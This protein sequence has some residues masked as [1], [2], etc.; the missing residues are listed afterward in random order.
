MSGKLK[1]TTLWAAALAIALGTGIPSAAARGVSPA[2]EH[3]A[4]PALSQPDT[5]S[6]WSKGA[7]TEPSVSDPASGKPSD[8]KT[9][10]TQKSK[11]SK[12]EKSARSQDLKKSQ[13]KELEARGRSIQGVRLGERVNFEHGVRGGI[14]NI[15]ED[16]IYRA[17][18]FL[19]DFL[20]DSLFTALPQAERDTLLGTIVPPPLRDSLTDIVN[21]QWEATATDIS[22]ESRDRV[23]QH[24]DTGRV[25]QHPGIINLDSLASAPAEQP[26]SF[27]VST[28]AWRAS[29]SDSLICTRFPRAEIDTLLSRSGLRRLDTAFIGSTA[30]LAGTEEAEEAAIH[31]K[32]RITQDTMPAGRMT[33]YSLIAP[34]YG[35]IYNRQAWKLPIL[36]GVAGGLVVGGVIT[37]SQFKADKAAYQRTID[38]R[39]PADQQNAAKA[40]M[41]RSRSQQTL[42]FGMAAATYL[43]FVADAV[44]NYRGPSDPVRK[45]TVLAAVFPGAGFVYTKTYWRLPIYYG[46][47]ITMATVIDYNNR[48][49]Q[50]FKMAYNAMTDSNPSTLPE[51]ALARYTPQQIANVRNSYRRD[52]DLGIIGMVAIYGLSIIDTYVIATLKNWDVSEDLTMHVAPTMIDTR[53]IQRTASFSNGAAYG[54]ALRLNF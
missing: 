26:F 18:N 27:N 46:G 23:T 20:R 51:P 14:M 34:G 5:T 52:R 10:K 35:Q 8:K 11:L 9:G 22:R 17:R 28:P 43:Y 16:S 1:Y 4:Q 33:L 30:A 54:L 42:M 36:Y 29:L 15:R 44:F 3:T 50:R 12:K 37:H 2:N 41:Q 21:A 6:V 40:A 19:S 39:L 47:F 32:F 13:R 38:L 49:Y 48:N 24:I 25:V 53:R 7:A 45:S 31:K